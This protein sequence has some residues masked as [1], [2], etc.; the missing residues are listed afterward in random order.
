MTSH[1]ERRVMKQVF[2]MVAS[3]GFSLWLASATVQAQTSSRGGSF[4]PSGSLGA[5]SGPNAARGVRTRAINP[6]FN[7]PGSQS[8]FQRLNPPGSNSPSLNLNPKGSIFRPRTRTSS[9]QQPAAASNPIR[10]SANRSQ[11]VPTQEQLVPTPEQ[12]V[13]TPEQLELMPQQSVRELIRSSA[14]QLE[15]ELVRFENGSDWKTVLQ[16]DQVGEILSTEQRPTLTKKDRQ[17]LTAT[18]DRFNK[19]A[20]DTQFDT[21]TQ[22]SGFTPLRSSLAQLLS[23]DASNG[24]TPTSQLNKSAGVE[25]P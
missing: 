7:P 24:R 15:K 1:H 11:L 16:L 19:L 2:W 21:V 18:L 14:R 8:A 3:V 9:G 13:P 5:R 12:L 25:T 4:N 22:L 17:R 10:H 6:N 23:V 20:T